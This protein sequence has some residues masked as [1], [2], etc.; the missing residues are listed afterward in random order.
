ML[1]KTLLLDTFDAVKEFVDIAASKDYKI[2]IK[3]GDF[4]VDAKSI[5]AVFSL[6]LTKPVE[7]QADCKYACELSRQIEKFVCKN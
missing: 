2:T 5:M 7:M 3:S 1:E 6:D 4:I